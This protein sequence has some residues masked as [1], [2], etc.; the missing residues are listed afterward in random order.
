ME[1]DSIRLIISWY[2]A[3][4]NVVTVFGETECGGVEPNFNAIVSYISS[5]QFLSDRFDCPKGCDPVE[6]FEEQL[7]Q[8]I[9]DG[10]PVWRYLNLSDW[11]M[12]M[13]ERS[14][15]AECDAEMEVL[16]KK[17]CC[18]RCKYLRERGPGYY[19]DAPSE[20]MKLRPREFDLKEKCSKFRRKWDD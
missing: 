3:F 18:L 7:T 5:I 17:Y 11:A 9:L 14:F 8:R 6:Y 20:R 16:R 10:F 12:E 13:I 19:C 2:Q 4:V 15:K 1:Q